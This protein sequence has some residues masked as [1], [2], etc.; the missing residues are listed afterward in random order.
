MRADR[1]LAILLLL[2]THRRLSARELAARLE[3]SPRTVQ[4]D[5]QALS[6]AGAPVYAAHGSQGGWSLLDGYH[7]DL[8]ALSH[9]EAHSLTLLAPAQLLDDL[10]LRQAATTGL[11]KLLASL[12]DAQRRTTDDIRQRVYVDAAGWRATAE[13]TPAFGDIQEALWRDR[14]VWM[15]YARNDGSQVERI[16]EPLG[17]VAKGRIWYLVA[18][19]EDAGNAGDVGNVGNM[20]N[21]GDHAP[22]TYRISRI[23]SARLLDAPVSRPPDF[24]LGAYWASA[25]AAFTASLPRYPASVRIQ[26]SALPFARAMWRYAT[27]EEVGS[28]DASGWLTARVTFENREEACFCL[29]G[30]ATQAEA[31]APDELARMVTERACQVAIRQPTSVESASADGNVSVPGA[32]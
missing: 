25:Q 10:G 21:M 6:S 13:Q 17:L 20:G 30:L 3:V 14:K 9:T 7:T 31:L 18:R 19:A 22:R 29:L 28:P 27:F 26:A 24:D 15:R 11:A 32:P 8:T 12:P 23:A 4:R 16:V 2:Q 5:M 1:L